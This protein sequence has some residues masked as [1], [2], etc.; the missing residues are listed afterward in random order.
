MQQPMHL[1]PPRL[2]K[3]NRT[4]QWASLCL[5]LIN[6]L[7]MCASTAFA[8]VPG[9]VLWVQTSIARTG[10]L[11]IFCIFSGNSAKALSI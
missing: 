6:T 11:N 1:P 3:K 4:W 2:E 10:A 9:N 7:L 5:S 8:E